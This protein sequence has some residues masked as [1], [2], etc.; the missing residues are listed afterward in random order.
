MRLLG[1]KK[2]GEGDATGKG[3][4]PQEEII[5]PGWQSKNPAITPIMKDLPVER[6]EV[7]RL[8]K[9]GMDALKKILENN[10]GSGTDEKTSL[11]FINTM[12]TI[13]QLCFEDADELAP[14]EFGN[15]HMKWNILALAASFERKNEGERADLCMHALRILK[16]NV[17]GAT[18]SEVLKNAQTDDEKNQLAGALIDLA[19]DGASTELDGR[20]A[21][22]LGK[23]A[24]SCNMPELEAILTPVWKLGEASKDAVYEAVANRI[25]NFIRE[26]YNVDSIMACIDMVEKIPEKFRDTVYREA[27]LRIKQHIGIDLGCLA[28]TIEIL[29]RLPSK[30]RPDIYH[31]II[32]KNDGTALSV[33]L[34]R[35][36]QAFGGDSHEIGI[37]CRIAKAQIASI[38]NNY[39]DQ[40]IRESAQKTAGMLPKDLRLELYIEVEKDTLY[41]DT[42]HFAKQMTEELSP[43]EE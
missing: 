30:N 6:V 37:I 8:G 19:L 33:M 10:R 26:A 28:K 11:L 32:D 41:H 42:R 38:L 35:L 5:P 36:E 14:L 3:G 2:K 39:E 7:K 40:Q 15:I 13:N 23:E 21:S 18:R 16:I 20:L 1:R 22:L 25:V 24:K 43:A 4:Q 27:T 34:T 12:K 9:E 29:G 17:G 31:R